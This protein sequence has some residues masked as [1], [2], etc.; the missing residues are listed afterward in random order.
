MSKTLDWIKEVREGC[1]KVI[2][3]DLETIMKEFKKGN[4][5]K[6]SFASLVQEVR[7]NER[8]DALLSLIQA[9]LEE[10]DALEQQGETG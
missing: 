4:F 6:S 3:K 5:E 7:D 8:E 9:M 10:D 2:E 1:Q